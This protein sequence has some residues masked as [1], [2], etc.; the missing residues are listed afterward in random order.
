MA[1][2]IELGL[3][4][5]LAALHDLEFGDFFRCLVESC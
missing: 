1:G 5:D 3:Q 2:V 4:R